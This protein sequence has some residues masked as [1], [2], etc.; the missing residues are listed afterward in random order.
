MQLLPLYYLHDD[1][2]SL[3]SANSHYILEPFQEVCLRR[4]SCGS[5]I[6]MIR[7]DF[8][9]RL[10]HQGCREELVS[11]ETSDATDRI[12]SVLQSVHKY[13]ERGV[14]F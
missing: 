8:E 6:E 9:R 11:M 5:H 14:I 10:Q 1:C 3:Q 7:H 2:T 4:M 12:Q 13:R